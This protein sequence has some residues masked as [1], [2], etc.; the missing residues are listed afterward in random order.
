MGLV[1]VRLYEFTDEAEANAYA[2]QHGL[3]GFSAIS[4]NF[5]LARMVEAVWDGCIAA[6]DAESRAWL[7]KTQM[8]LV[9]WSSQ[10]RGFF[11]ERAHPDNRSDAELVRC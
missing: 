11:T 3:R 7:A 8:P 9:P 2:K 5:S 10:A 4:N 6:S 1:P